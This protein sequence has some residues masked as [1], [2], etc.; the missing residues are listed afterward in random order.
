[1]LEL[2]QMNSALPN[3][4]PAIIHF[5][6]A[7]ALV[8]LLC[9]FIHFLK[10]DFNF[11]SDGSD[12]LGGIAALG[13]VA[14]FLSGR[15]AAD[16]VGGLTSSAEQALVR[17]AEMAE[18]AMVAL[19]LA[20][21]VQMIMRRVSFSGWLAKNR[22]RSLIKLVV[23]SIA[24]AVVV[25][26][27]DYGGAL[28]YNHGVGTKAVIPA[29]A[30]SAGVS[31]D[32]AVN[33]QRKF[34]DGQQIWEYREGDILDL[35]VDG[36]G[37]ISLPGVVGDGIVEVMIEPGD[38]TGD[39]TLVH[40]YETPDFWEGFRFSSDGTMDLLSM[41][42][43]GEKNRNQSAMLFPREKFSMRSSAVSGHYKG[44]VNNEVLVH[45]HGSSEGIGRSG[46]LISGKGTIKVFSII[47]TEVSQ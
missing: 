29:M 4:H 36:S 27:A 17:H 32:R 21:L 26:T 42:P 47:A 1:M 39:I 14:A 22:I 2:L 3:L 44:L 5:P 41:S 24:A 31:V 6:I 33:S 15:Q 45:G 8:A 37:L 13:A 23:L 10:P 46:L 19:V 20:A 38:F 11:L 28:V 7:M 16:S 30:A 34:P 9:Q 43:T 18:W 12:A 25:I 40:R 35:V